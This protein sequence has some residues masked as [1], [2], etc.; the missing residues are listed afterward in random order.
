[1]RLLVT[2]PEPDAHELAARLE[3]HG[4]EATL[5]P[6]LAVDFDD[7]EPIELEGVQAL[8]ATSRNGVR[9]LAAS[10]VLAAA[11]ALPL[12]AV[13]NATAAEARRSGFETVVTGAGTAAELVTHIV[14]VLDPAAGL[15]AHLAGDRLAVNLKAELEAHGYRV[16]Q[17]VVYRTSA[18]TAL[19]AEAVEQ[20]VIGEIDGVVLMSPRTASV[21]AALA[22][23]QGLATAVRGLLHFC[24]SPAVAERL[25]PLG[26]SRIAVAETPK[27]EEMLA[28]IDAAAA[29]SAG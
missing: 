20:L 23:R 24:L 13:G 12:F 11:R 3:E 15:I 4:H 17:P 29:R 28:L 14:S 22:R 27:M 6:L 18:A 9:A 2:R 19:S 7:G 1:M 10:P 26:L 21:Y 25:R 5:E 16:L 8:V